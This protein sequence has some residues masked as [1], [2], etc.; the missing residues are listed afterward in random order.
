M[1]DQTCYEQA[2]D[3]KALKSKSQIQIKNKKFMTL[4]VLSREREMQ[5]DNIYPAADI[6]I[7]TISVL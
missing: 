7:K 1:G 2:V 6:P 4:V 3:D 5:N